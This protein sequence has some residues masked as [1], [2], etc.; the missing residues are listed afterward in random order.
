MIYAIE[1]FDVPKK[2]YGYMVEYHPYLTKGDFQRLEQ[3]NSEH[4]ITNAVTW[5]LTSLIANRF[6]L[7]RKGAFL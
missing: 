6:L 7:N 2:D 5:L 3:L 1:W 4:S